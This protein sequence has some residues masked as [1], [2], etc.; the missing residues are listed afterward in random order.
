MAFLDVA[1]RYG[2]Q[3]PFLEIGV[4]PGSNCIL[5][6]E[7]FAGKERHAVNLHEF[8]Q[9][10][11]INFVKA[12]SNDLSNVFRDGQF[13][14]VISNAVLEHDR[15]FWL[16]IAEMHRVLAP[17]GHLVVSAPGFIPRKQVR[18]T[19]VGE[20]VE[21]ATITHDIHAV[22]DYWRFSRWAFKHVFCEGLQ[23]LEIKVIM[24]IPRILAV[25]QK[26]A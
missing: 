2:L 18:A 26:P 9:E 11:G 10:D 12:N 16:S 20:D 6:A 3:P 5:A 7:Y 4:A 1:A 21:M 14:T 19:V 25:A 23:M 8:K 17:G 15:F 22:P 24:E 13:N